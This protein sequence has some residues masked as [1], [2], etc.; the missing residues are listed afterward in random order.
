MKAERIEI[1]TFLRAGFKKTEISKHLNVSR[2]IVHW[3]ELHLK[4]SEFLKDRPQSGRPQG[5]NQELRKQPIPE[6][7]KNGSEEEIFS[8]DC[9]QHHQND[10]RKKSETFQETPVECSNAQ[11]RIIGG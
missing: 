2:M 6:N 1:S 11:S 7:D 9:V 8:L 4:A 10:G 5:L 3:V